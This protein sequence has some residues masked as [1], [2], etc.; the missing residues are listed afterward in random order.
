MTIA[1]PR[2][3]IS[4]SHQDEDWKD[5][6]VSHLSVLEREGAL[7]VWNDQRI[8]AGEDWRPEIEQAIANAT[9]AILIISKDFLTSKFIREHELTRILARR[10]R[11]ELRV[12]PV[13]AEPCA[14]Q[15]VEALQGIQARP[16]HGRPLSAGS[17]HQVNTDLSA[18][19]L[20]ILE[21]AD[22]KTGASPVHPIHTRSRTRLIWVC[23]PT[24]L[25]ILLAIGATYWRVESRISLHLVTRRLSFE[26]RGDRR[27]SLLDSSGQFS[28]ISIERCAGATFTAARFARVPTPGASTSD[29]TVHTGPV[30]FRCDDSDAKITL[31]SPSGNDRVGS[32][33]TLSLEP[34]VRVALDVR[35]TTSPVVT[36]DVSTGQALSL[37]VAGD[38][39][40]I[41]DLVTLESS[42]V[43]VVA[44]AEYEARLHDS[45]RMFRVSTG[46]RGTVLIVTPTSDSAA[47]FFDTEPPIAIGT[48]Q[49]IDQTVDGETVT[50]FLGDGTLGYPDYPRMPLV[51][52]S[53][54]D[55]LVLN[56]TTAMELHALALEP[57]QAALA[58]TVEG[59]MAEG[60]IG[61]STA[62]ATNGDEPRGRWF[63]PRLTLY[64]VI[65]YGSPW[66]I[67]AIIG[68][69]VMATIW[70]V[71]GRWPHLEAR[72]RGSQRREDTT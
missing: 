23:V 18:L 45:D 37:P 36:I 71:Y 70:A 5:R 68:A 28:A 67:V 27:Q 38:V 48:L 72:S 20:E 10:S 22:V 44:L 55:F 19:A 4:Y 43:P 13:I 29:A 26:M 46:D 51:T 32:L 53:G 11:R 21:M 8:A 52:I 33:D 69:W 65:R 42:P 34:G 58:L 1:R 6:L 31:A 2:V 41:T 50:P 63:D 9:I 35:G 64:Q 60:A 14:W 7:D 16:R 59:L 25:L 66:K 3:F 17:E 57:A 49:F 56:R 47:G 54:T 39:R 24:I 12:I 30:R 15:A 40:I 61:S 62:P